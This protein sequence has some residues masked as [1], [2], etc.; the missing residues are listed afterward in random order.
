VAAWAIAPAPALAID[1]L[2][3]G[4]TVEAV[5]HYGSCNCDLQNN[6]A[7]VDG[8]LAQLVPS[9]SVNFVKGV[10][11]YDTTVY[12]TDFYDGNAPGFT[13]ND[14]LYFDKAYSTTSGGN[15]I[16]MYSGHG[17]C[18][19]IAYDQTCTPGV[20]SC[21]SPP[22]GMAAPGK[23][24]PLQ[25]NYPNNYPGRCVYFANRKATVNPDVASNQYGGVVDY[26]GGGVKLGERATA[27]WTG[28]G[29]N[30]GTNFVIMDTSC[31]VRHHLLWQSLG[32]SFQGLHTFATLMMLG[33]GSDTADVDNRG[34]AFGKQ[35][36]ANHN[37]SIA[38]SWS[39]SINS[40]TGGFSHGIVGYGAHTAVSAGA[41]STDAYYY[42][43]TESFLNVRTQYAATGPYGWWAHKFTCNYD[44]F[45]YPIP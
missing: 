13:G 44:C 6:K 24:L 34:S 9:G 10:Y 43:D 31:P 15:G 30:G 11:Y 38:S 16:A 5:D 2:N 29:T 37:A 41:N 32:P 39:I 4:V 27:P 14:R 40:V 23:C 17:R 18:D 35:Y 28:F 45:N 42:R 33:W 1:A 21:N 7:N 19:D 25:P 8:L 12:D 26:S 36:A 3:K 22:A 20:S